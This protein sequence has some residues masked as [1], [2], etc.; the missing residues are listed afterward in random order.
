[1]RVELKETRRHPLGM[2]KEEEWLTIDEIAKDLRVHPATVRNLIR[3]GDL[4]AILVGK[5]TY[6]IH[7]ND[8]QEFLQK[9]RLHKQSDEVRERDDH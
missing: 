7:R 1:M 4:P 8:Y 6:R 5:R 9:R 3:Q 2:Q